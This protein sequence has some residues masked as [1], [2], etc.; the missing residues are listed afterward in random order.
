MVCFAARRRRSKRLDDKVYRNKI[1]RNSALGRDDTYP[2]NYSRDGPSAYGAMSNGSLAPPPPPPIPVEAGAQRT[3]EDEFLTC[4]D[5]DAVLV[6]DDPGERISTTELDEKKDGDT[7]QDSQPFLD[8]SDGWP[9]QMLDMARAAERNEELG[10]LSSVSRAAWSRGIVGDDDEDD[11]AKHDARVQPSKDRAYDEDPLRTPGGVE[12]PVLRGRAT[13][14][15]GTPSSAEPK[16]SSMA[17]TVD[18]SRPPALTQRRRSESGSSKGSFSTAGGRKPVATVIGDFNVTHMIGKG[19]FGRVLL[20]RKRSGAER[21]RAFAI[22]VLDKEVVRA[23]GQAAHTRA[24]RETLAALRH[25]FVVRLRYAFQSRERLYLV[26][27]FYAGGSLERHLDDAHPNGIGSARTLYYSAALVAALRHCHAAGVVHR[28][29]KP[30]NVLVDARGDVALTDF[31]L[32][33]LGVVED[34]APLRSF[35]GT[36]TYMAPELLVGNAYGTSVDWWALGALIFEMAAGRPPFE[37]SNRRRMFYTILH[38]PPPYPLNFSR[39][40]V[41]LLAGLLEKRPERRLGV[42]RPFDELTPGHGAVTPTPQQLQD[43]L[44]QQKSSSGSKAQQRNRRRSPLSSLLA[45]SPAPAADNTASSPSDNVPP[46]PDTKARGDDPI[47]NAA[48][49]ATI[50][51][52]ALLEHRMAPP[53]VPE[54]SAPDDVAYVPKRVRERG[55][56][57]LRNEFGDVVRSG[58]FARMGGEAHISRQSASITRGEL[59]RLREY[60]HWDDFSYAAPTRGGTIGAAAADQPPEPVSVT[61]PQHSSKDS[62][63]TTTVAASSAR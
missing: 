33:A 57:S 35:C 16:P 25:P 46:P 34:G 47:K 8:S 60:S 28:D 51:W 18:M 37:D 12:M 54:L 59:D 39:E 53:W 38:I 1:V 63:A 13:T 61:P 50:D 11:W 6:L 42:V 52:L 21:G 27:D 19:A 10:G 43:K 24:E 58:S 36:V 4:V 55:S 26:T 40:L 31:G 22:K 2:S 3:L 45:R 44:Q 14:N 41:E 7:V 20:A 30:G 48:Y 49:F 29:I 32:C 15:D 5:R 56:D 9:D 23:T 17:S 62:D